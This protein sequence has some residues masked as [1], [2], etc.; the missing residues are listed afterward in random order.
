MIKA[1]GH[2]RLPFNQCSPGVVVGGD[3]AP[4][5]FWGE[6]PGRGCVWLAVARVWGDGY[7]PAMRRTTMEPSQ[8]R[9]SVSQTLRKSASHPEHEARVIARIPR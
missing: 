4:G 8:P 7:H 1:C 2:H 5:T 9:M 6:G 3:V